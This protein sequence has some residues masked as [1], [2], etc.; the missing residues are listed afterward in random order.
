MD[1]EGP[2]VA[3]DH[4]LIPCLDQVKAPRLRL[5]D[6]DVEAHE[7]LHVLDVPTHDSALVHLFGAE[8]L[9]NPTAHTTDRSANR[10]GS[11]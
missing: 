8:N 2:L 6:K 3:Q 5:L 4:N 10:S 9:I 11:G 1:I 7:P